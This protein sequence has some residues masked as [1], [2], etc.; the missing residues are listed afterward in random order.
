MSSVA[1]SGQITCVD[2]VTQ[3]TQVFPES[4]LYFEGIRESEKE[5]GGSVLVFIFAFSKPHLAL[6]WI[7]V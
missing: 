5:S 3:L 7:N 1:D 2:P 4:L 6:L